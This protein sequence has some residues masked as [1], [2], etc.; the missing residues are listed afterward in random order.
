MQPSSQW[1]VQNEKESW[2]AEIFSK[3]VQLFY[4]CGYIVQLWLLSFSTISPF[5]HFAIS[6]SLYFVIS[7]FFVLKTPLYQQ[8]K[9]WMKA[10]T[11]LFTHLFPFNSHSRHIKSF[12]MKTGGLSSEHNVYETFLLFLF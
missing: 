4:W 7:P 9:F 2:F 3:Y 10:V 6:P 8:S 11:Y 1:Q 5:C 12:G